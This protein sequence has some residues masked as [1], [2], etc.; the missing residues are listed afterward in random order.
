MSKLFEIQ[1]EILASLLNKSQE[2]KLL[3]NN[4]REELDIYKSLI[5]NSAEKY[6]ATGFENSYKI[7]KNNWRIII[8]LYLE[9]FPS[10]SPIYYMIGKNFSEYIQS[11]IFKNNFSYP[12]YLGELVEF[13]WAKIELLNSNEDQKN[14]SCAINPV[15]KILNFNYPITQIINY[16]ADENISLEDK[17]STNI[18]ADT[19]NLFVYRD[20]E[21]LQIKTFLLSRS[22][23]EVINYLKQGSNPE[24][25]TEILCNTENSCQ[26]DQ[27]KKELFYLIENL[28]K[29]NILIK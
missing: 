15:H 13:E 7:L 14:K 12:N 24:E 26:I 6:L 28:K 17:I 25:I 11:D 9:N 16:L 18:E 19:E 3:N 21:T 27:I 22:V 2:F 4:A 8:K 1:Q 5:L 29:L 10:K 23:I 20:T